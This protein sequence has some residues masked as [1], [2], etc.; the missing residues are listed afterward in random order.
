MRLYEISTIQNSADKLA[1]FIR[2]NAQDWLRESNGGTFQAYRGLTTRSL[3][4]ANNDLD[5][6]LEPD[7]LAGAAAF[8]GVGAKVNRRPL[9]TSAMRTAAFNGM[10]RAVG[11]VADR[12]NSIFAA[13]KKA[14]AASYGK[15]YCV[16]PLGP[17]HYTWSPVHHDWTTSFSVENILPLLLPEVQPLVRNMGHWD[18]SGMTQ[19]PPFAS[20]AYEAMIAA[21]IDPK[22]YD[23]AKVSQKI[24]V[25]TGWVNAVRLQKEIMIHCPKVLY[26]DPDFMRQHFEDLL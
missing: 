6:I 12:S 15:P 22:S 26:V 16:I 18:L 2:A 10:I 19:T 9:D 4:P 21:L 8:T 24:T 11:G 20:K 13:G 1:I 14:Q 17:F 23:K 7:V 5:G 25:D 3:P